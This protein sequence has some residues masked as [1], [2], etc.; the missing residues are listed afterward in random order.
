MTHT[1]FQSIAR[2]VLEIEELRFIT[3]NRTNKSN[4]EYFGRLRELKRLAMEVKDDRS[5]I[6]SVVHK[7]GGANISLEVLELCEF[8]NSQRFIEGISRLDKLKSLKLYYVKKIH[9]NPSHRQL[10]A[11]EGTIRNRAIWGY[12]AYDQRCS[13][14]VHTKCTKTAAF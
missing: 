7:V 3:K 11:Y 1:I 6:P 14:A 4:T 8:D 13:P 12:S 10:Q 2:Y 9:S 5:Y